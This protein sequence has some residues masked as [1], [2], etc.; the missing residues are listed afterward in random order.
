MENQGKNSYAHVAAKI[1][2]HA[3][4]TARERNTDKSNSIP[5]YL[6]QHK[7]CSS[8]TSCAYYAKINMYYVLDSKDRKSIGNQDHPILQ[9]SSLLDY[10]M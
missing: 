6:E 9:E 10:F 8:Q 1:D 3:R 4:C 7:W 2:Y 5:I